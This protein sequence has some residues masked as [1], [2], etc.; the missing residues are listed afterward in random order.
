[1]QAVS[2]SGNAALDGQH[3]GGSWSVLQHAL[4]MCPTACSVND[5]VVSIR[6]VYGGAN[7]SRPYYYAGKWQRDNVTGALINIT[8][9]TVTLEF[10]SY[11]NYDWG[12]GNTRALGGNLN[13]T[14][15][16]LNNCWGALTNKDAW[17]GKKYHV[18]SCTAEVGQL[19]RRMIMSPRGNNS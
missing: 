3:S 14:A 17:L 2:V 8:L 15:N 6:N 16:L 18:S 5:T 13:A 11:S 4:I 7:V 19:V 12:W 1:V 10:D 9:P